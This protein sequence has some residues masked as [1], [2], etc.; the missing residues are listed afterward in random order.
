MNESP[1]AA[2]D[3]PSFGIEFCAFRMA[4]GMLALL[5]SLD[6]LTR[7]LRFLVPDAA[8][9]DEMQKIFRV[10]C[11]GQRKE[12]LMRYRYPDSP[13]ALLPPDYLAL[14]YFDIRVYVQL[15]LFHKGLVR[16]VL[17]LRN[18]QKQ[19]CRELTKW[20][21]AAG[22]LVHDLVDLYRHIRYFSRSIT[23]MLMNIQCWPPE[24]PDVYQPL[25]PDWLPPVQQLPVFH[26]GLD[27]VQYLDALDWYKHEYGD[28]VGFRKWLS[29]S[30]MVTRSAQVQ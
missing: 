7:V 1:P 15:P 10:L 25:H 11:A 12:Q 13:T 19:M 26:G 20:Q 30:A 27:Y 8:R 9:Y 18:M 28:V 17:E 3:G 2:A 23:G 6:V 4:K 22:L 5:W 29:W 16:F 21:L 14:C 24:E